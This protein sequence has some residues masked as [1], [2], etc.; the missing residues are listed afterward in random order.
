MMVNDCIGHPVVARAARE[1]LNKSE[2]DRSGVLSTAM[3]F[4][5]CRYG[6]SRTALLASLPPSLPPGSVRRG[7]D[8]QADPAD[9]ADLG[10]TCRIASDL[11]HRLD[12]AV[13][14]PAWPRYCFSWDGYEPGHWGDIAPA[15]CRRC[16]GDDMAAGRDAYLR[17][18]FS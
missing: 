12:L 8:W 9:L 3:S 18:A 15:F 17:Q 5:S 4:L 16:F 2:N 14:H 7:L 11:L 13:M 1:L 6:I 10:E